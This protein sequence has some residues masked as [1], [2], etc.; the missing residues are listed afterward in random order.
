MKILM[1]SSLPRDLDSIKGGVD[2]AVVNLIKG[3][4]YF[5]DI[6]FLILSVGKSDQ[7]R[8]VKYAN[9]ITIQYLQ[10]KSLGSILVDYLFFARKKIHKVITEFRPDIIHMQGASPILFCLIGL[11]KKNLVITQHGVI[12][13]EIKFQK[14]I[15]KKLKFWMKKIIE[16]YYF[17]K[18]HNYTFI[19]NYNQ[20]FLKQLKGEHLYRS[21]LIYNPVNPLFFDLKLQANFNKR[22]LYVGVIN[23]LKNLLCLLK[24]IHRIRPMVHG[25]KVTV[26]GGF[27]D[28][29]YKKLILQF[30]KNN[31]LEDNISFYGWKSQT[32]VLELYK[33]V[34]LFVLPSLQ[35]AL[36]VSIAEAMA[37]GRPVIASDVGG[38]S[39]MITAQKS[40]F[41][42]QAN[43]SQELETYLLKFY[44]GTVCYY[45]FARNAREE[46]MKKFHPEN[47]AAQTIEFYKTILEN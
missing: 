23:H 22:I 29:S 10:K 32:E 8:I 43:N 30:I 42:F 24:A 41:V 33:D 12:T 27:K 14:T 2:A 25:L 34:D 4:E 31:Q 28:E 36:P 44:N 45:D 19:S 3:F 35:E 15:A 20:R 11:K 39:E 5:P 26:I 13:E 37:A 1:I 7:N 40:G 9:N 6:N 16:Q 47:V 21:R 38:V 46:A 18:F 17:P